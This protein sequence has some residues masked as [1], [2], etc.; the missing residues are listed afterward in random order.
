MAETA[1]Q[2][3]VLQHLDVMKDTFPS[4]EEWIQALRLSTEAVERY[5][6]QLMDPNLLPFYG[7]RANA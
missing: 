3:R 1:E 5:S 4:V 6:E 7:V 2:D